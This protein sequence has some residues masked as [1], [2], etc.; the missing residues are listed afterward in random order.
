MAV[1]GHW[2]Q[3]ICRQL[4]GPVYSGPRIAFEYPELAVCL[5]RII[6]LMA[7]GKQR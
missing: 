6:T 4:R 3:A 7:S 2:P 5:A 1:A